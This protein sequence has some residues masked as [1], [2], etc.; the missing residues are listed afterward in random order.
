MAIENEY[1]KIIVRKNG[2]GKIIWK[3]KKMQKA[4]YK[5]LVEQWIREHGPEDDDQ[6][7]S[8]L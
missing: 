1:F 4:Y 3:N 2:T 6:L 5:A 7:A 8:F